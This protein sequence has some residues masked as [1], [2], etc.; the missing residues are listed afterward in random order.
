MKKILPI[1]FFSFFILSAGD[2]YAGQLTLTTYYPAP[3]GAY[4]KVQLTN[5]GYPSACTAGLLFKDPNTGSLKVCDTNGSIACNPAT[6]CVPPNIACCDVFPT[7]CYNLFCSGATLGSCSIPAC[8]TG[9][10]SLLIGGAPLKDNFQVDTN[11]F[12]TSQ[13]CCGGN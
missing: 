5:T 4:N 6:P 7:Q 3:T 2:S 13:V 10:S 12:V 9:Y 1:L 8:A 11:S